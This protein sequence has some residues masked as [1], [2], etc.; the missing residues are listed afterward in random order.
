MTWQGVAASWLLGLGEEFRAQIT[1]R[2]AFSFES[3]IILGMGVVF[4]LPVV[5]FFLSRI[6]L[7]TPRFLMR[8][9]RLA[10]LIIAPLATTYQHVKRVTRAYNV[11]RESAGALSGIEDILRT[12]ADAANVGGEAIEVVRGEVEV[13]D[14]HFSYGDT[15]VLRAR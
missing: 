8:H 14:L 6:G 7:V 10:V 4:E 2:S 9:F 12:D 5:I 11:L 1:L 3:W 13:R 15:S